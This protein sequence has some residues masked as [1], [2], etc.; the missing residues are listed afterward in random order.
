[1][2]NGIKKG[3]AAAIHTWYPDSKIFAETVTQGIKPKTFLITMISPSIKGEMCASRTYDAVFA[4]QYF[5]QGPEK[6][7]E[8]YDVIDTLED[9]LETITI[10]AGGNLSTAV[11]ARRIKAESDIVDNVLTYKVRYIARTYIPVA[12]TDMSNVA[13]TVKG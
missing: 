6:K 8:I 12:D 5:P 7:T 10:P 13:V 11:M 2:F 9:A 3:I 1:M 4:I